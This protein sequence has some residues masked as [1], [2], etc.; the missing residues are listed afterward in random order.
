VLD[1]ATQVLQADARV[2]VVADRAFGCP[3]LTDQ[4]PAH[5]WDW[6]VRV[7]GQ[8]RWRDRQGRIQPMV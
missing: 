5:G 4:A 6:L 3:V 2:V 7:Q 8:T 1:Q